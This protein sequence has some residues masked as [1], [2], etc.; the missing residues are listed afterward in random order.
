M[1]NAWNKG[2]LPQNKEMATVT[3]NAVL[4]AGKC[5]PRSSKVRSEVRSLTPFWAP[6]LLTTAIPR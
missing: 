5:S 4:L 6:S 1:H 3:C 2:F